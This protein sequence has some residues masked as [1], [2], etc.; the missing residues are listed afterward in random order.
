MTTTLPQPLTAAPAQTRQLSCL[1]GHAHVETAVACLGSLLR[2]SLEPLSLTLH[3]DGS[4][5]PADIDRLNASLG[6]FRLIPRALADQR[7]ADELR[8][9]PHSTQWRSHSNYALKVFDC[10]AFQ[11]DDIFCEIDSDILFF[12]PF[13]NLFSLAPDEDARF[14]SDHEHCYSVRSWNL[15]CSPRLRLASRLN[16]GLICIRRAAYDPDRVEWFLSQ[17]RHKTKYYFIEQTL[18]SMLAIS[19]RTRLIPASHIVNVTPQL[20]LTDSLVAAHFVAMH[21]GLLPQ[22]LPFTHPSSQTPITN[23]HPRPVRRCTSLSL[24][25]IESKRILER[26]AIK[27]RLL[28]KP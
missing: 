6:R 7:M 26:T 17:N 25:A 4:L 14:L 23:F 21:R 5:T 16:V 1:L 9:F 28:P 24:A 13:A 3:D 8:R 10:L 22:Y 2:C 12:K 11:T 20:T 27:C 15:L 19:L 18:W